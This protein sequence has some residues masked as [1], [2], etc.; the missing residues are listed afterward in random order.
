MPDQGS[1]S[2]SSG[3]S[4]L[5]RS[6]EAHVAFRL[7]SFVLFLD[8]AM[9]ISDG[10]GLA[11]LYANPDAL[12]ASFAFRVALIFVFYLLVTSLIVP[13]V[14]TRVWDLLWQTFAF[15]L[16]KLDLHLPTLWRN[17]YVPLSE[18]SKEAHTSK[19]PYLLELEKEEKANAKEKKHIQLYHLS[20]WCF[21]L[22]AFDFFYDPVSGKTLLQH[23]TDGRVLLYGIITLMV[24]FVA[25]VW[26]FSKS[27][28][29]FVY[30]PSL[31]QKHL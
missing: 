1:S 30:C 11:S 28:H 20:F 29:K 9:V 17:G 18:V 3:L 23:I 19:E 4:L 24:S 21:V 13:P 12:N 22:T 8:L 25:L 7:F 26:H 15:R 6:Q 16:N 5:E 10:R 27:T 2:L 31:A 14:A